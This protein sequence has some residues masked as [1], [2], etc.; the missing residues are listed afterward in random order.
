MPDGQ[1]LRVVRASDIH[2]RGDVW[3]CSWCGAGERVADGWVID[4]EDVIPG[5]AVRAFVCDRCARTATQRAEASRDAGQQRCSRCGLSCAVGQGAVIGRVDEV[6]PGV[7][8]VPLCRECA[9][10]ELARIRAIPDAA[11]P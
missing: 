2:G 3:P 1:I 8:H 10:S 5:Q 9:E 11:E 7:T 6:S 4:H